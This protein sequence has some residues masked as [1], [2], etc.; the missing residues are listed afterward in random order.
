[1]EVD[2]SK[3]GYPFW[4]QL[5]R[6]LKFR[7]FYSFDPPVSFLPKNLCTLRSKALSVA[8][9]ALAV[10]FALVFINLRYPDYIHE[11]RCDC[12]RALRASLV[13]NWSQNKQ[14][15]TFELVGATLTR[16]VADREH[17]FRCLIELV[18]T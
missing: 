7:D 8:S 14:P 4:S 9:K 15:R 13:D 10:L 18:D 1:V 5:L 17:D 6:L 3:N 12:L 2:H 11:T 16:A